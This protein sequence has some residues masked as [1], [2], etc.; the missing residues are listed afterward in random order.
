V[1]KAVLGECFSDVH[2]TLDLVGV[3]GV[4]GHRRWL[5]DPLSAFMV[6]YALHGEKG[7]L[8]GLLHITL[9]Y[10]ESDI[11]K[12]CKKAKYGLRFT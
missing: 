11:N 4:R 2:R 5:H 9:D 7:A 10:I 3:V 1:E 12:K 6:G 8:S